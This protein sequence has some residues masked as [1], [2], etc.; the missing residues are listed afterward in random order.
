MLSP[1]RSRRFKAG[2]SEYKWKITEDGLVVSKRAS[3]PVIP[4]SPRLIPGEQCM[5]VSRTNSKVVASWLQ[6]ELTLRVV[7][8]GES[9]LDR[10]VVSCF[11]NLWMK[12]RN[13]W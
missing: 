8:R 5:S 9:M 4:R 12:N 6:A 3:L 11:L 1:R 2:G 7:D 10:V 13:L